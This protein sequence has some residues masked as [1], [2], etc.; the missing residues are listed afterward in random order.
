V[1]TQKKAWVT[2]ASCYFGVSRAIDHLSL[3]CFSLIMEVDESA[4]ECFVCFGP[5]KPLFKTCNC[6]TR[7]HSNCFQRLLCMPT[8]SDR[9][10]VCQHQYVMTPTQRLRCNKW[11]TLL[12]VMALVFLICILYAQYWVL[13]L[14][15]ASGSTLVLVHISGTIGF[16]TLIIGLVVVTD[17][18]EHACCCHTETITLMPT[19]NSTQIINCNPTQ[20]NLI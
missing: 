12:Y 10:P 7:V 13:F 11:P 4:E 17:E 8:H 16:L 2:H 15:A 14:T 19:A 9:C 18:M 20:S 6:N 5:G 1:A 3:F